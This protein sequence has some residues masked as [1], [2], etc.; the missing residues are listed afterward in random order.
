MR[1]FNYTIFLAITSCFFLFSSCLKED[2]IKKPFTSIEPQDIAD[3]WTISKPEEVGI[4]TYK[5]TSII[6]NYHNNPDFWQIRSIS[7]FKND[8]LIAETYCKDERD[9]IIGRPIWSCTK[10]ILSILVGVA[11]DKGLISSVDDPI[12][13]YLEEEIKTFPDKRDITIKDLLTMRSGI[14]FTNYGLYS[15]DAAILQQKPDDILGFCLSKD[16]K[17]TPGE[18]YSYKDSDPQILVAILDKVTKRHTREWANE[19]LFK[20]LGIN[21]IE[22]INYR[23]GKTIGA[24]GI[25]TTPRELAKVGQLVLNNGVFNNNRIVSEKWLNEML[26]NHVKTPDKNFGYLWWIDVENKIYYM[27]GNG[28]QFVL[29]KPEKN[30]MVV[31]TSEDKTQGKARLYTSVAINL[32]NEILKLQD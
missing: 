6:Q 23:D 26:T 25:I 12:E 30:L 20:P 19:V 32:I 1:R 4:S 16:M 27:S 18:D 3:N 29:L 7:V 2:L 21:N 28:G 14:G 15:D 31:I 24:F 17:G 8:R 5:L 11:I 13:K 10:Q 22:W 9:R